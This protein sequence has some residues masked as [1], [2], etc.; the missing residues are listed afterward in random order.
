M[1][2]ILYLLVVGLFFILCSSSLPLSRLPHKW[3]TPSSGPLFYQK[4]LSG[5]MVPMNGSYLTIGSYYSS[6]SIGSPGQTFTVLID[7][8]SSNLAVPIKG[9]ATCGDQ[10]IPK[11]DP[12][13]SSTFSVLGCNDARCM[14]CSPRSYF[15]NVTKCAFQQPFCSIEPSG[16][17]GFGIT[18]GGGSSGISGF[19]GYDQV[20]FGGYCLKDHNVV[21]ITEETPA[22]SFS[23]EP[24]DGIIGFAWE[25]NAC[26]PTCTTMIYDDI[27]RQENLPNIISMCLTANNGG[28]LD[29]GLIDPAKYSGSIVYSPVT[30]ERW[31]NIHVLD[32]YVG[33]T[34]VG[35]PSFFYW[36]TNDVIG[37]FVDS[38]TSVFLVAPAM[39][40]SIQNI[41]QTQ[42]SNLPGVA[43][44][45]FNGGCVSEADMGNQLHN[46]PTVYVI[47]PDE[48][49]VA[50][51]LPMPP[52]SYLMNMNQAYCN[53]I[54]GNVGTGII[55]GDVFMQNYYI[56]FD[57]ENSRLGFAPLTSCV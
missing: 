14:K 46:F 52:E 7:T 39:F 25:M 30:Q 36:T 55:M 41:F 12:S 22:N 40:Q 16:S 10:N 3:T 37:G 20:C 32:I 34:S 57:K 6:I 44:V 51:S 29:L 13:Q 5:S 48:Q 19:V 45:L 28:V 27:A 4:T 38:G 47:I 50:H 54:V 23:T 33:N 15:N 42:Y 49:G 24:I 18:Y 56:V 9:C 1:K 17:C 2:P 8:G 31:W 53:G 26:N 43:N 21:Y 35:V 11:F